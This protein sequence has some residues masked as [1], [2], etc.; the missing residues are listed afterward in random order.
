[1]GV[2]ARRLQAS[3]RTYDKEKDCGSFWE[4]GSYDWGRQLTNVEGND[5]LQ[6]HCRGGKQ[7]HK[8]LIPAPQ[9]R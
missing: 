2:T 1:M 4:F 7:E 5:A 6:L 3:L 9:L 8:L